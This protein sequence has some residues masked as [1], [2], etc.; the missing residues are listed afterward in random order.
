VPC[1][2]FAY[3]S[4]PSSACSARPSLSPRTRT[5]GGWSARPKAF[6]YGFGGRFGY[7]VSQLYLG[8][9]AVAYLGG[10]DVDVTETA[11]TYGEEIGYGLRLARFGGASLSLRPIVGFGAL[12]VARTDP[13]LLTGPSTAKS[14]SGRMDVL[15][16]ATSV[17]SNGSSSG[18][19]GSSASSPSDTTYVS[20]F[21][22]QPELELVLASSIHFVS[23]GGRVL[24]VPAMTYGGAT[25]TWI[26]PALEAQIGVRW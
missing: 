16:G 10:T 3:L 6:G 20:S 17:A 23:L 26:S 9:S 2:R 8:I 24:V 22:L 1:V 12:T 21:L 5:T 11:V 13:S 14:L 7:L 19:S 25:A 18:V 4:P 15:S